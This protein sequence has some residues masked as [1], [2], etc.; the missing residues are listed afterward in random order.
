MNGPIPELRPELGPCWEWTGALNNHNGYPVFGPGGGVKHMYAHRYSYV[1]EHGEI[2]AGLTIDH[3]CVNRI[4]VRPSH[5]EAVTSL[6]N[7]LRI[8]RWKFGT[9]NRAK[10]HCPHDHPL[11]GVR[12][13]GGKGRPKTPRR[14]CKTCHRLASERQKRAAGVQPRGRKTHCRKGHPYIDPYWGTTKRKN[15][16]QVCR[17][18]VRLQNLKNTERRRAARLAARQKDAA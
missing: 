10:T 12:F 16:Y 15:G 2:P 11:D 18:C 9:H 6:E 8:P 3:L 13:E 4:C 7:S 1:L 5:L 14:Y 17:E